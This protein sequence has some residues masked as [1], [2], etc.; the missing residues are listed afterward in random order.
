M[1]SGGLFER[2]RGLF[3]LI[4][5]HSLLP[6]LLL[7]TFINYFLLLKGVRFVTFVTFV[8]VCN[9]CKL[10]FYYSRFIVCY[11]LLLFLLL[12]TFINYFLLLRRARGIVL[13]YLFIVQGEG[14]CLD[15]IYF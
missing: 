3:L 11:F 5:F 4:F 7:V 12:V 9:F 10:F 1:H 2:S 15:F 13:L 8:T 14:V 6:F